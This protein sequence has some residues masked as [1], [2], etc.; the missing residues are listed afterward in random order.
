[1]KRIAAIGI[2]VLALAIVG[3]SGAWLVNRGAAERQIETAL[4]KL[5]EAGVEA[6]FDSLAIAGFPTAYEGVLTNLTLRFVADR[7]A[8]S[9]PE[10][11]AGM[12]VASIGTVDFTLP[13]QFTAMRLDESGAPTGEKI[14]V[15]SDGL[16]TAV[17]PRED[18]G[19]DVALAAERLRLSPSEK[20]IDFVELRTL[21]ASA[22]LA[23]GPARASATLDGSVSAERVE[24]R[25]SA[26]TLESEAAASLIANRVKGDVAGALDKLRLS[27]AADRV[28]V[29]DGRASTALVSRLDVAATLTPALD[30]DVETI[31]ATAKLNPTGV[32]VETAAKALAEKGDLD[33]AATIGKLDTQLSAEGEGAGEG[34]GSATVSIAGLGVT[35]KAA[36]TRLAF[37][38][39][40]DNAKVDALMNGAATSGAV[41]AYM[42]T[43]ESEPAGDYDFSPM[44]AARTVDE[45]LTL[46][47]DILRAEVAN[48]GSAKLEMASKRYQT[49]SSGDAKAFGV[50]RYATS[51]GPNETKIGLTAEAVDFLVKSD[52]ARYEVEGAM[53]GALTLQSFE[54][55]GRHPLKRADGAQSARLF[56]NLAEI[57]LD[58]RLWTAL[59]LGPKPERIPGVRFDAEADVALGGDLLTMPAF[60][61][62]AALRYERV[63]LREALVQALGFKGEAAGVVTLDP[64]PE[65]AVLVTLENWAAFYD[66][67][68]RSAIAANPNGGMALAM[69]QS[70]IERYGQPGERPNTTVLNVEVAPTGVSV[71][72]AKIGG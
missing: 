17:T 42:F 21:V 52:A 51:V 67:A 70:W 33:V 45:A 23:F 14:V 38:M 25:V 68:S 44:L 16:T 29:E 64:A 2:G 34:E 58:Q 36:P 31:L 49:E 12:S 22:R 69:M 11:A 65:G 59:G 24:A 15:R 50:A 10:V 48:G 56:L 18:G 1:M 55:L 57:D 63:S 35:V 66:R 13:A 40:A 32:F 4:E 41:D 37:T 46:F 6:K 53:S 20:A 62:L 9:F 72:G 54:L 26:E 30:F 5:G 43:A 27:A 8:L 71:N 39:G 28:I 61:A 47:A 60:M 3:L 19:V 7:V